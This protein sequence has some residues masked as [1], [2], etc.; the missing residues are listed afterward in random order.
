MLIDTSFTKTLHT[1][2]VEKITSSIIQRI[3]C[4]GKG[5]ITNNLQSLIL[6]KTSQQYK[7]DQKKRMNNLKPKTVGYPIAPS[8]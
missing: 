8:C 1:Q 2:T 4:K 6:G 5:T 3:H 7:V